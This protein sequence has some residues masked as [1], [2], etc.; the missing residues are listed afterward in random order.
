MASKIYCLYIDFD[1]GVMIVT[2][3]D[4]INTAW[5]FHSFI[6]FVFKENYKETDEFLMKAKI[7]FSSIEV[8]QHENVLHFVGA[9]VSDS[10]SKL[11]FS[12]NKH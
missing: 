9:V 6:D 4:E 10:D 3:V 12:I 1:L 2:F 5:T 8:G 11:S 7:N